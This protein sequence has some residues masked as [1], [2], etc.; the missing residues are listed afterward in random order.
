MC[1]SQ[2]AAMLI[3]RLNGYRNAVGPEIH[4]D[5]GYFYHYHPTR[6]HTGYFSVHIWYFS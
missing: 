1:I 6:N 4:G 3:L 2:E 5:E